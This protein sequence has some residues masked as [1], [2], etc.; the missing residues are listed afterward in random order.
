MSS[1]L[2]GTPA[3]E[4]IERF[5]E[6]RP[7]GL[8]WDLINQSSG[9]E[10]R[11]SDLRAVLDELHEYQQ[12]VQAVLDYSPADVIRPG[13]SDAWDKG[14]DYARRALRARLAEHITGLA[15]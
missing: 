15:V 2:T 8:A 6:H 5:L 7:S 9:E 10:I 13:S 14:H 4:R 1:H 11:V 12:A 3:A